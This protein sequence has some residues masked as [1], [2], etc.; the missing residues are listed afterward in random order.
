MDL[1]TNYFTI[2]LKITASLETKYMRRHSLQNCSGLRVTY[3]LT[4]TEQLII[5]YEATTEQTNHIDLT[6]H[7]Y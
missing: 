7:I 4:D 3:Q 2:N 6:N 1:R 5:R